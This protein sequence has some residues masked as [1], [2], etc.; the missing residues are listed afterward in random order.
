MCVNPDAGWHT[1]HGHGTPPGSMT[2]VSRFRV[3]LNLLKGLINS[4]QA[5]E[6]M[7]AVRR[8]TPSQGGARRSWAEVITGIKYVLAVRGFLLARDQKVFKKQR[9]HCR[10][11]KGVTEMARCLGGRG[12][13]RRLSW[14]Q[15][16]GVGRQACGSPPSPGPIDMVLENEVLTL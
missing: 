15:L 5:P 12:H 14:Q 1:L 2:S 4:P 8:G 7:E 10:G 13:R 16:A 9:C 11:A 3:Q 6:Q